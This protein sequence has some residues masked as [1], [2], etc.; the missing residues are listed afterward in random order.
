MDNA[1]ILK[2]FPIP[3]LGEL[4]VRPGVKLL[5]QLIPN[6]GGQRMLLMPVPSSLVNAPSGA[7]EFN[8]IP[9]FSGCVAEDLRLVEFFA[10]KPVIKVLG[11]DFKFWLERITTCQAFDGE[12]CDKNLTYVETTNGAIRLCWHHDNQYRNNELSESRIKELE[13]LADKNRLEYALARIRVHLNMDSNYP[14]NSADVCMWAILNGVYEF[15]PE[16]FLHDVLNRKSKKLRNKS[17]GF[18]DA[19]TEHCAESAQDEFN[20]LAQAVKVLEVDDE[21]YAMYMARPKEMRWESEKYLKFVRSLPCVVT[22][23]SSN[24]YDQVVPHHLIGYGEGKMGGKA[25]DV[26]TFPISIDEHRKLHDNVTEWEERNG[27]QL[28]HVKETIKKAFNLGAL[29]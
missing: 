28:Y 27:S 4:L 17:I 22:G 7:I 15:L 19:P 20:R 2:V 6:L 3:E 12:F 13:Q 21:P 16:E 29:S 10:Q 14:L 23:K 1:V 18:R 8:P 9:E 24:D 5:N 11:N 25:H 26:F